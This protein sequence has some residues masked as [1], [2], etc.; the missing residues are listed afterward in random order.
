MKATVL[1]PLEVLVTVLRQG[2][3]MKSIKVKVAVYFVGLIIFIG[4]IF[5]IGMNSYIDHFYYGRKILAMTKVVED[6]NKIYKVSD[7]EDEALKYI[8]NL[9]YNFEGE[10]SIFEASTNLVIFD[11]KR[12]QYTKG[13]IVEEITYGDYGA[14]VY[15]TSFPVEGARWLI[16]IAPLDNDKFALLQISVVSLDEAVGV[17]QAF[18][19]YMMLIAFAAAFIL[20]LIL[21]RNISKPI[22]QIHKVANSIGSLKFD[23][24]Y[25]GKRKDEIGQ[26]GQRLNQISE[27]LETTIADLQIELEKGKSIDRMRRHFVAQ[28]SH[29]LQTPISVISSYVEAL[30]DGIVEDEEVM[31]YYEV[32]E[33]E[34][35]K[36]SK[37][38]KELLQLSQLEADSLKF[39]M[40]DIEFTSFLTHIIH[41]YHRLAVK[42]NID[43][44]SDYNDVSDVCIKGDQLRLEQGITNILSNAFKHSTQYVLVDL[45]QEDNRLI[46]RIENSGEPID[47]QD[48]EHIFDSFYKG[49]TGKK[50]EGTG[51][52]LTIASRIFDKHGIEYKVYNTNHSVVFELVINRREC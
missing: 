5:T 3:N 27:T 21:A 17:F 40:E 30:N 8:E 15:E 42:K 4:V 2:L 48:I 9:G 18:F 50:K 11:S 19:N 25:S 32:I 29:E 39:T 22:N 12:Y 35:I 7:S 37:I 33:D 20:A 31:D 45:T 52:G 10:I 49:K 34:S 23:S 26:L 36:M 24:K 41:K 16:Y 1:T 46:L 38:V 51:L 13:K 28:V 6:I 14:Y 47:S 43:L 44:K